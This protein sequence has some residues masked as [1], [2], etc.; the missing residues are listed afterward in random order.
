MTP[1]DNATNEA[2]TSLNVAPRWPYIVGLISIVLGAAGLV[3]APISGI[4][5]ASLPC[6]AFATYHAFASHSPARAAIAVSAAT[7]AIGLALG[8]VAVYSFSGDNFFVQE[9]TSLVA[10]LAA[11]ILGILVG[12]PALRSLASSPATGLH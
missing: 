6:V 1:D 3:F 12:V 8:A 7:M 5:Y 11:P 9:W 4:V 2:S 10:L